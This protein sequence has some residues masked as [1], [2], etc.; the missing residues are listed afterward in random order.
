[1]GLAVV[2]HAHFIRETIDLLPPFVSQ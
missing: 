1:M 2:V